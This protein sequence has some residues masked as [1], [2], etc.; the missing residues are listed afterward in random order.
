MA[1]EGLG[2]KFIDRVTLDS[3]VEADLLDFTQIGLELLVFRI[4]LLFSVIDLSKFFKDFQNR[5]FVV[6]VN[7]HKRKHVCGFI[8]FIL[9]FF[10]FLCVFQGVALLC[11]F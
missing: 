3:F 4:D 9:P 6:A 5:L 2:K 11:S 10:D 7:R 1:I 8:G